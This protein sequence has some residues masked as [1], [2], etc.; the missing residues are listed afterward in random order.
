MPI[1][2]QHDDKKSSAPSRSLVLI[3][4]ATFGDV[5]WRLFVPTIGGTLLG[6]W[7]DKSWHTTPWFTGIGIIVGSI[8]AILLVRA[9]INMI[10]K[11]R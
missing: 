2:N 8:S 5:T 7:A 3:M 6:L 4:L 1:N 9:Q 10:N 11:S